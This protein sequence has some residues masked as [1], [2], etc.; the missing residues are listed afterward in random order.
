MADPRSLQDPLTN[1]REHAGFHKRKGQPNMV[2]L[3]VLVVGRK[4]VSHLDNS[5]PLC[6]RKL[7]RNIAESASDRRQ[8]IRN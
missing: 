4:P 2:G 8:S 3:G 1:P 7:L 5:A 6:P